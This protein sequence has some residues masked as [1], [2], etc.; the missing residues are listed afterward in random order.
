MLSGHNIQ[1]YYYPL[2]QNYFDTDNDGVSKILESNKTIDKLHRFKRT[3]LG[4]LKRVKDIIG[5]IKSFQYDIKTI[6]DFGTQRGALLFPLID[7]FP[8]IQYFSIDIDDDIYNFLEKLDT[9]KLNDPSYHLQVIQ[10]DITKQIINIENK[11]MDMVIASEIL[12]HLTNPLDAIIEAV[13]IAKKYIII[14]VPSK[15]DNNP[16]HIQ[17]FKIE[18]ML[19]LLKKIGITRVN[20]RSDRTY[21]LFFVTL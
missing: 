19:I 12:E 17:F 21:D 9:G 20:V 4:N 7:N 18:D 13:R 5:I 2:L 8:A 1:R 15:P 3:D 6:V 11:S 10:G 16:E 14:T